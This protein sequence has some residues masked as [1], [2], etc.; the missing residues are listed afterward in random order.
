[1]CVLMFY[2]SSVV[3]CVYSLCVSFFYVCYHFLVKLSFYYSYLWLHLS[4]FVFFLDFVS[5][6]LFCFVRDMC[7]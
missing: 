1:M 4:N 7:T 3:C 2:R 6:F 5:F